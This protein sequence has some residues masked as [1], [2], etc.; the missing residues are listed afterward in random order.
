MYC[1]NATPWIDESPAPLVNELRDYLTSLGIKTRPSF[2]IGPYEL[3]VVECDYPIAYSFCP[4]EAFFRSLTAD[5]PALSST[6]PMSPRISSP[7]HSPHRTSSLPPPT[8]L[9][10]ASLPPLPSSST[11]SS[12]PS[13][14]DDHH[15]ADFE[16]KISVVGVQTNREVLGGETSR[17]YEFRLEWL[18]SQRY[19]VEKGW[20]CVTVPFYVWRRLST[21]ERTRY[22][23]A[24]RSKIIGCLRQP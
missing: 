1:T 20:W 3:P 15:S 13:L 19:L 16:G 7:R 5:S 24:K 6:S 18:V 2:H 14:G 9:P 12:Y 21:A 4:G 8:S 17:G 23:A 10:P 22:L 11:G